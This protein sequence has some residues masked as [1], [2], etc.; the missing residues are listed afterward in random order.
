MPPTFSSFPVPTFGAPTTTPALPESTAPP[1]TDSTPLPAYHASST[2]Q[3]LT[4]KPRIE[5]LDV[6]DPLLTQMASSQRVQ[7]PCTQ[8]AKT[9]MVCFKSFSS[10]IV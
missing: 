6:D 8:I 10:V 9:D 3:E 4:D 1:A 5:S 7:F 2:L